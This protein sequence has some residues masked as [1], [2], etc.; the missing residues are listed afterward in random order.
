MLSTIRETV[1]VQAGGLLQLHV[2]EFKPY[3]KVDVVAVM[4]IS[5]DLPVFWDSNRTISETKGLLKGRI[6]DPMDWQRKLRD[7]WETRLVR[8][9]AV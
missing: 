2:K 1:E 6:S 4:E 5:D 8:E 9:T 3:T 7:E